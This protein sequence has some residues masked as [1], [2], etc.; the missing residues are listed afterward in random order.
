MVPIHWEVRSRHRSRRR[1][2][3]KTRRHHSTWTS[4][5]QYRLAPTSRAE[6]H[7]VQSDGAEVHPAANMSENVSPISPARSKRAEAWG[8]IRFI[9]RSQIPR[10]VVD[11]SSA[12]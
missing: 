2:P 10:C 4:H 6:I 5:H 9:L 12:A 7:L 11:P 8:R 1:S 3:A